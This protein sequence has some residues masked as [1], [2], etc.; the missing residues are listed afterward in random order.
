MKNN[1]EGC[2]IGGAIGDAWGSSYEFESITDFSKTYIWGE[3][4][5]EST[6]REWIITDDTQLTLATCEA[7]CENLYTPEKLSNLFLSYYKANKLSGIGASTLK[8]LK[9]LEIGIHWNLSGRTGEYAA[10]NGVAMRIA[11]FAFF[12]SISREDI[13]NAAKITHKNDEAYTGALSVFLAIKSVLNKEWNGTNDLFEIII[14]QLPDT[15]VRD[16]LIEISKLPDTTTINDV[17]KLGNNGY[18]VNSVP[19]AIY[20]ATKISR[21]GMSEM[22]KEIIQSGGDTDTN[23]SIAGQIAGALVGIDNIPKELVDRIKGI[24]EYSWIKNIIDRTK[25]KIENYR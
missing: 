23:S 25:M 20:S 6:N 12:P 17:S 16:R 9:D 14:N 21:I 4:P 1:F 19:F 11:P 13:Y 24:R 2:I 5:K 18:V 8:A 22:F 15:R 3:L 7:L 10:G